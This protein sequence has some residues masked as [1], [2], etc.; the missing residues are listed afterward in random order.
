MTL[1]P[2]QSLVLTIDEAATS[3]HI[4]RTHLYELISSNKIRTIRIGPCR[5]IVR[6]ELERFI[7][8]LS[9]DDNGRV[10]ALS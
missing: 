5:R 8:S 2:N 3:L 6:T 4:G 1:D 9:T 10:N 7:S